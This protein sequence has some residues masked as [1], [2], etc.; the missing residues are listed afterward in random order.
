M[1]GYK[2]PNIKYADDCLVQTQA[3]VNDRLIQDEHSRRDA[4]NHARDSCRMAVANFIAGHRCEELEGQHSTEFR[5]RVFVF[6]PDE[7]YKIV[8]SEADRVIRSNRQ[9]S[10]ADMAWV[11]K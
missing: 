5:L 7:F 4:Y 1:N 9:L 10:M 6:T 3:I 8:N 2:F 11:G